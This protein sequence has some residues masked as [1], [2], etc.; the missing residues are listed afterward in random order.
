MAQ[1]LYNSENH[2]SDH[3]TSMTITP[4]EFRIMEESCCRLDK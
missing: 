2:A 3:I 4:Q 1:N